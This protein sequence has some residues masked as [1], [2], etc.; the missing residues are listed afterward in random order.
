[1]HVKNT[2]ACHKL[3]QLPKGPPIA[4]EAAEF[5]K[6]LRLHMLPP[7]RWVCCRLASYHKLHRRQALDQ[8]SHQTPLHRILHSLPRSSSSSH[9]LRLS[10][11]RRPPGRSCRQAPHH[12]V[13]NR[14]LVAVSIRLRL[15]HRRRPR[16]PLPPPALP[17]LP[18]PLRRL[19]RS[20][21][22]RPRLRAQFRLW[23]SDSA[24]SQASPP[25]SR[26][27]SRFLRGPLLRYS[28]RRPRPQPERRRRRRWRDR[29]RLCRARAQRQ[30]RAP[31]EESAAVAGVRRSSATTA[32][33][34][35][36]PSNSTLQLY[37]PAHISP[38]RLQSLDLC[39]SNFR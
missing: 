22:R 36:I 7:Q 32:V 27:R 31:P 4:R 15:Q 3:Y 26:S 5:S 19:N 21:R 39:L 20:C 23:S 1:M 10:S 11:T 29:S 13:Q 2:R 30:A 18:L 28:R 25:S 38:C 8:L 9:H 6:R 35:W 24:H 12:R 33:P 16:A 34:F 37:R 14:W 17:H